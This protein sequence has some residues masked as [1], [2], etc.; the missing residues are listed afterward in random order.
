VNVRKL[1]AD[2]PG[3]WKGAVVGVAVMAAAAYGGPIAGKAVGF[4]APKALEHV[5]DTP[6]SDVIAHKNPILSRQEAIA[7]AEAKKP[8]EIVIHVKPSERAMLRD[9]AR[10]HKLSLKLSCHT[11]PEK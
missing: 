6:I 9:V 1:I 8:P 10:D 3:F 2:H 7:Q 11:G 4:L 5:S